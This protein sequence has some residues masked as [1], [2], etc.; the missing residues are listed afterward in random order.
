MSTQGRKD[1]KG[2]QISSS[3][4][5]SNRVP[6]TGGRT[7][8]VTDWFFRDR[9]GRMPRVSPANSNERVAHLSHARPEARPP[10]RVS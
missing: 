8:K 6:C 10:E 4:R 3:S 9:A 2:K 5:N 7:I 1:P